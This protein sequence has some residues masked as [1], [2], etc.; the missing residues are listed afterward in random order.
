M[1]ICLEYRS[2]WCQNIQECE[3][4]E[5]MSRSFNDINER[6]DYI[7]FRQDLLF[8]NSELCRLIYESEI[9][10]DEYKGIMDLM[11]EMR[12]RLVYNQQV[13]H[14][15]FEHEMYSIVPNHNGDYHFCEYIA[16]AFMDDG[17]WEEV[18][19][20]LYGDMPKYRHLKG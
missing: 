15:E 1:R 3:G 7:E 12:N 19:P 6:L 17:R 9:T 13:S 18:F 14:A 16:R 2:H 10:G 11:E 8:D 20:A 4:K 5:N